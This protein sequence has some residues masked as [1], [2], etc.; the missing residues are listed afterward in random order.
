MARQF[1]RA[2]ALD[3]P[4]PSSTVRHHPLPRAQAVKSIRMFVAL[5]FFVPLPAASALP[6]PA[7]EILQ[8]P[9]PGNYCQANVVPALFNVNTRPG[10]TYYGRGTMRVNGVQVSQGPISSFVFPAGIVSSFAPM[11]PMTTPGVVYPPGTVFSSVSTYFDAARRPTYEN[12][13]VIRCDTG[14]T[15][16]IRNADLTPPPPLP[17][18]ISPLPAAA[19]L[20][21]ASAFA[22]RRSCAQ[23][24]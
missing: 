22:F 19:A 12:E 4:P 14:Q 24:L 18:P 15:A 20:L 13:L 21:L 9:P 23:T 2:D 16:L 1:T 11:P 6:F 8:G 10:E 3:G 17:V 7:V 5:A